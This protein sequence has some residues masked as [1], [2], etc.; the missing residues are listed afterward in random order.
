MLRGTRVSKGAPSRA[1][2]SSWLPPIILAL[3]FSGSDAAQA[4]PI[5][6]PDFKKVD[7]NPETQFKL[8]D[9]VKKPGDKTR[10]SV[11]DPSEFSNVLNNTD[12]D[13][14]DLHLKIILTGRSSDAI[15]GDVNGDSMIGTPA[16]GIFTMSMLS[17]DKKTIWLSG[18]KIPKGSAFSALFKLKDLGD[19][20]IRVEGEFSVPEPSTL[21]LLGSTATA[22]AAFARRRRR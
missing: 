7:P 9:V 3:A 1:L 15:W 13:I 14:L 10:F 20:F 16:G 22:L 18:G 5:I 17:E 8:A 4:V 21:L 19:G 6:E 12:F 11:T 2:L